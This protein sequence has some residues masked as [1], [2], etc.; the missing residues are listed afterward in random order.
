MTCQ[1]LLDVTATVHTYIMISNYRV[2]FSLFLVI[3][4]GQSVSK[5]YRFLMKTG[6]WMWL[7]TKA[8]ISY[9]TRSQKAQFITCYNYVVR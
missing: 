5:S 2:P 6:D 4:K 3:S 9:N 7:Q 8:V 1:P